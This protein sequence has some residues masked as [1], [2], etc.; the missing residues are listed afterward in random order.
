M[1]RWVHIFWCC[2]RFRITLQVCLIQRIMWVCCALRPLII[3]LSNFRVIY[4]LLFVCTFYALILIKE[5]FDIQRISFELNV[6]HMCLTFRKQQQITFCYL[7]F[8]IEIDLIEVFFVSSPV[9]LFYR[10]H[11]RYSTCFHLKFC[12]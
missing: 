2:N 3:F 7:S 8:W 5:T 10:F 12:E 1:C 4:I 11:I 9:W 6:E